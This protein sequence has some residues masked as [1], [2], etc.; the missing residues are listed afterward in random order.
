MDS[1]TLVPRGP[2]SLREA[3]LFGFGQRHDTGFDGTMRLAFCVDGWR[4]QA[5][6]AVTQDDDGV[7]HCVVTATAGDP[8]PAAVAAQVARV[9]SLDHDAAGYVA[10]GE[11]DPVVA[12]LLAAAPGLRPPLFYSPYEAA[13]WAVLSARRPRAQAEGWR[14]AI[15]AAAGKP[16][17]VAGSPMFAL[18]TP[19]DVLA[20][21]PAGLAGAA[22]I[23]AQR[24]ERLCGVAEA[25]AA[26]T[27]AA[28]ELAALEPEEA[29]RRLQRIKGIGPFYADLVLL[30]ATGVTDVLPANE[31]RLLG[32][33]GDL[34]RLGAPATP[35][36]AQR[37]AEVWRPW[38]TWVTVLFRAAGGR[39][40]GRPSG[41]MDPR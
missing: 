2:F 30:R 20:L 13:F 11:R 27:L 21:G 9:L 15:S 40:L 10:V 28:G 34:Y 29:R 1:F 19:A 14:R 16:L 23:D 31:P 36:R 3:A 4:G 7:V 26:G 39:V 24:A 32:L 41:P 35:E 37:L 18:P 22:G 33:L 25:A 12:S 8:D 6:V 5:G 38:R 17:P